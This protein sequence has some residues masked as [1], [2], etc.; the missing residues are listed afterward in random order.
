M[1]QPPSGETLDINKVNVQFTPK[2]GAVT[3]I[4][5]SADCSKAAGWHFD[6]PAAPTKILMCSGACNTLLASAEG[7]I[8]IVFGCKTVGGTPR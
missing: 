4:D 2:G 8:D 3:T 7:K 6:N 5:Y 1:G